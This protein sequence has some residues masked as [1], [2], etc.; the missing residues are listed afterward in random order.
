MK[1]NYDQII[2]DMPPGL[3]RAVLRVLSSRRGRVNA[4]KRDDIIKEVKRLNVHPHER[5]VREVIKQLRLD[6]HVI[7]SAA[8]GDGGYYMA[9]T[10]FEFQE[11]AEREFW[12]KITDMRETVQIMESAAAEQFGSVVQMD[13][14]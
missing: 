4:I 12:A 8:S 14:F 1:T 10:L 2:K 7:C 3:D 9:A 11:F 5:Q 13:L 6:G